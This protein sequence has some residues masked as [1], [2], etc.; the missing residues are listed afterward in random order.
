[1]NDFWLF[2]FGHDAGLVIAFALCPPDDE[3]T[4]RTEKAKWNLIRE[5]IFS[6]VQY[7]IPYISCKKQACSSRFSLSKKCSFA[8]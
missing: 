4:R 6:V 1:M 5:T 7:S 8:T 3:Y 2:V